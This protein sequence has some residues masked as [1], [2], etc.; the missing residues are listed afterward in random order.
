MSKDF[1]TNALLSR[2]AFYNALLD[3]HDENR[4]V[5]GECGYPESIS[6]ADYI[7]MYRRC[8]V[9]NRVVTIE[10][11]KCWQDYPEIYET[12]EERMT[13]FEEAVEDL[14]D[15][16]D[17]FSYMERID[18]VS[19]IGRYGV[20]FIGLDDGREFDT[21]AP[22]YTENDKAGGPGTANPLYFR[23][24]DESSARIAEYETDR[25]N[26]R[27]GLPLYYD[28]DF[29]DT[30]NSFTDSNAAPVSE[31][32]RVHW[33][34]VIHVA[35][36]SGTTSE[37][38]GFP[39]QE[40]VFNRLFDL[41]KINAASGEAYWKGGFPGY[42][43]EVDPRNGELTDEDRELVKDEIYKWEQGLS[44]YFAAVGVTMKALQPTLTNP[45]P[46]VDN[47]LRMIS[48][49]KGYPM[50]E[51]AASAAAPSDEELKAWQKK[52]SLRRKKF[53]DK[54]II[55]A[56]I[57]RMVQYGAL[58][59]TESEEGKPRR[60]KIRW[61]PLAE[62]TETEKAEVGLKRTEALARYATAGAEALVPL[63]E[64]LTKF[65]RLS[66]EE[67]EAIVKAERSEFS[68]VLQ[69]LAKGMTGQQNNT[70]SSIPAVPKPGDQ[71][72]PSKTPPNVVQPPAQ[73]GQQ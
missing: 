66:F 62:M 47:A 37:I 30:A 42:A 28:L 8:D 31:T 20:L 68:V 53:V 45:Q 11:D 16:T 58:P 29:Q 6:V 23:V 70:P 14:I 10:P 25:T 7:T 61:V 22:G 21:P 60:Y 40:L 71:K 46:F 73:E 34:R 50:N 38:F 36:V 55:R 27:Y 44:R 43:F 49:A 26:P 2:A 52:I 33:S 69:E 64:W 12:D 48:V 13:D 51:L 39:R 59:P 18:V 9:A 19:G 4:D 65:L 3:G 72:D 67:A 17:L 35:D 63:Q 5:D 54:A 57:D 56:I 41:R 32:L 15:R 1:V 24:F